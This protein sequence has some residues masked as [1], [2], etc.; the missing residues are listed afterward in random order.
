MKYVV[1]AAIIAALL[2]LTG[3]NISESAPPPTNPAAAVITWEGCTRYS[4]EYR[5]LDELPTGAVACPYADGGTYEPRVTRATWRPVGASCKV[6]V[7]RISEVV[8]HLGCYKT[9]PLNPANAIPADAD[10]PK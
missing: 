5:I 6:D 7:N 4:M 2:A 8:Q 3:C 9:A 1:W 10:W